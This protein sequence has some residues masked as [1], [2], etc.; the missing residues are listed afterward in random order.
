MTDA[1]TS[2]AP[3]GRETRVVV[4]RDAVSAELESETVI[5]GMHDG[6]YHGLEEVGTRIWALAATPTT[7]GAIHE[8]IAA[9]YDVDPAL[10]WQDLVALAQDLLAAGLLDHVPD[11]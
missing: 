4:S 10:A 2:R 1:S 11:E 8:V 6:V 3:L 5:L 7:L 9:E